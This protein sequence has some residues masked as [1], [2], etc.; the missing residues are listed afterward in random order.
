MTDVTSA[1]GDRRAK[2]KP[3]TRER[4]LTA[5]LELFIERGVAGTTVSDIERAVGLA[6]GTGSFYRH[7][8]S[9]E[10][11]LVAAVEH[12]IARLVDEMD[13]A[14]AALPVVDDPVGR[15]TQDYKA[16]LVDMRRFFPLWTLIIA[17]RH[18]FPELQ[19]MFTEAL[20]VRAWDFG[21]SED[22][23]AAIATA[24]LTGYYQLSL[25]GGGAYRDIDPDDFI[26]ALIGLTSRA[27]TTSQTRKR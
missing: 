4:I 3:T 16:R 23:T 9:K 26:A 14:R 7:F 5:A 21:W 15:R 10:E 19:R 20:G 11:V 25:L 24:A 8:G 1:D 17:E 6:A 12:G 13:G 18:R 2:G 27:T 22:P